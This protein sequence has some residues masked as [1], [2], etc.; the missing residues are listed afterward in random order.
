MK[1]TELSKRIAVNGQDY[2]IKPRHISRN[3]GDA[4]RKR[5]YEQVAEVILL[6]CK[7]KSL[8]IWKPFALDEVYCL[9]SR[10]GILCSLDERQKRII[11][12]FATEWL[13]S[14]DPGGLLYRVTDEFVQRCIGSSPSEEFLCELENN[15]S[16]AAADASPPLM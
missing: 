16:V 2:P 12:E 14:D 6:I 7:K 5:I 11:D 8:D 1:A 15:E 9:Y 3:I 10:G 4:F 13:I